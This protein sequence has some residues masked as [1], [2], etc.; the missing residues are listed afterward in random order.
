V[1]PPASDWIVLLRPVREIVV[2]RVDGE[3]RQAAAAE[4]QRVLLEKKCR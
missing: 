1:K 2:G 3:R 4:P